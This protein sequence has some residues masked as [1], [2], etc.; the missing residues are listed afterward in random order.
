MSPYGMTKYVTERV[1]RDLH[2]ARPEWGAVFLR[3][4]NPAGAHLGADIGEEPQGVPNNL[5]PYIAQVSQLSTL[6]RRMSAK[7]SD[8]STSEG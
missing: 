4:F 8:I 2:R 3:Y 1:I 6:L 7:L 5:M